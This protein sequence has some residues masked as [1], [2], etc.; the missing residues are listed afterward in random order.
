[1]KE[2]MLRS[3]ETI[4]IETVSANK[5]H[6]AEAYPCQKQRQ[7]AIILIQLRSRILDRAFGVRDFVREHNLAFELRDPSTPH[8]AKLALGMIN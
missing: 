1:M 8:S 6:R 3:E 2:V 4:S 5:V 7:L